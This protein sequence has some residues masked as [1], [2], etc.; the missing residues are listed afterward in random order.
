MKIKKQRNPKIVFPTWAKNLRDPKNRY[1]IIYGGRGSGKS[2]L[3]ADHL[4]ITS[5][6]E[7]I[8]VLCGREFQ[9]S[10][11]DSVHSLL[12]QRINDLG[13]SD[14]F[15]VTQDEIRCSHTGSRFIFKGLRQNISSIKSMAGIT[16]LWIEEGDTLSEASWRV[17]KPTIREEG[18]QIIITLNPRN[19]NDCI[20][21]D[22]IDETPPNNAYV[23]KVNW[24]D[25]PHFPSTLNDERLIDMGKDIGLY[26]HVWEGDLLERSESQVFNRTPQLWYVEDFE[27]AKEVYAYYGLDFGYS[28]DP[29][30]AVRCYIVQNTLYITHEFYETKVEIDKIGKACET[31]IPGFD[32]SKII[33]D[34]SR[35]ET[36]SYMKR[37]GYRV[38][39]S[40]KGKGSVEDGIAFIRSFDKVIIHSRCKNTIDE[41]NL[42]SYKVD[43]RSGDVTDTLVDSDNH[44]VDALRYALERI[45]RRNYADYSILSAM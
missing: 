36:I 24:Q 39:G 33:A 5:Y 18:S 31:Q 11:K 2:Y 20:Y 13:L 15:V 38:E 27:E 26:R 25:N 14:Y 35:P 41:F 12:S 3:V 17:I 40:I 23:V 19:K 42:Y 8:I 28:I 22:F 30:A 7:N 10:I 9:N 37:Q 4:L 21:K 45:M 43:T 1:C 16:H 6:G 34:S 29:T 32:N 44:I